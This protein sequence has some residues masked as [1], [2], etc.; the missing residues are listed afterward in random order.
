MD[1][2]TQG[3]ALRLWLYLLCS[4][5]APTKKFFGTGKIRLLAMVSPP[6]TELVSPGSLNRTSHIA[7]RGQYRKPAKGRARTEAKLAPK[8]AFYRRRERSGT[9]R[10]ARS[11]NQ[12]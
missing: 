2:V 8:E 12:A 7:F 9:Q 6:S 5:C 1:D 4:G 11:V 3:Q 10:A